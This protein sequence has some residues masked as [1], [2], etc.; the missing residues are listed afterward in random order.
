MLA[1]MVDGAAWQHDAQLR[2][3]RR[4][5]ACKNVSDGPNGSLTNHMDPDP[6]RSEPLF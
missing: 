3:L 2:C 6:I 1:S 4:V 5:K